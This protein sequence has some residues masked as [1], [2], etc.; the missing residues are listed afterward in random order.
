MKYRI[1]LI[2]VLGFCFS[3]LPVVAEDATL[4]DLD[5]LVGRWMGLRTTLALE[6][7]DW[8]ARQ[9]QWVAEIKLL[10]QESVALDRQISTFTHA[11]SDGEKEQTRQLARKTLMGD[12]LDRLKV[13]L[14]QAEAALRVWE[15][16]IPAGLRQ[17]LE[18]LFK[19]LPET[20]QEADKLETTKRVQT[21]VALF[22]Q[23]EN[24]QHGLHTTRE[25]LHVEAGQRRQ[26]DVIYVGL[27][28]AYAVSLNDD[29][30]AVGI[31]GETGWSWSARPEYAAQVRCAIDVLKRQ[32]AAELI[33]LPMQ[34]AEG[35]E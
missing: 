6:Q 24:L 5:Q 16:R 4:G 22:T 10:E 33:Y 19:A 23:I 9:K 32:K 29:W 35:V 13:K 12:E 8:D 1:K 15:S 21:L 27:A 2:M 28:C 18:S 31:P 30:A 17:S 7:R 3:L 26:V 11:A 20:R 25:M 14:D 34:L